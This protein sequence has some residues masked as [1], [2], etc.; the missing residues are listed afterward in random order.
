MSLD[1]DLSAI[2]DHETLCWLPDPNGNDG[3]MLNPITHAIILSTLNV[4]IGEITEWNALEFYTRLSMAERVYGP[5]L[6]NHDEESDTF[7]PRYLTAAEVRA[8]IGLRTNVFPKVTDAAWLENVLRNHRDDT[9]RT[10]ER[11]Q[12]EQEVANGPTEMEWAAG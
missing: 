5:M 11:E 10:W 8:H 9:R 6:T 1:W 7:E 12:R 4:G 2:K 3:V